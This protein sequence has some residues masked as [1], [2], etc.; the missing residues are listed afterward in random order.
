LL[1]EYEAMYIVDVDQTDEQL[2][3]ITE[4]YKKIVTSMGGVV[5]DVGKW[6]GGRRRLAYPIAG[7]REGIYYLMNFDSGTDV[8]KEL[9]R[10]FKISDDVFRHLIVKRETGAPPL[11]SSYQA[12]VQ[13]QQPA[14]VAPAAAEA[15]P[16]AAPASEPV[17]EAPAAEEPVVE[18]PVAEAVADE[19]PVIEEAVAEAPVEAV[20][21]V[22][23][24][25][26]E[27]K[28]AE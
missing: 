24:P 11:Q 6:E 16:D 8:P 5:L 13:Q 20:P 3:A 28:P 21:A 12:P 18:L 19:A 23:E 9:D 2:E 25:A 7:R 26:A 27:T 1:R 15:T 22:D 10:I 4:K 17:V 14:V